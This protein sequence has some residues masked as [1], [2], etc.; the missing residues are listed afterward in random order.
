MM[1]NELMEKGKRKKLIVAY[2]ALKDYTKRKTIK[3][4]G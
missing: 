1:V 2:S 4:E 3:F